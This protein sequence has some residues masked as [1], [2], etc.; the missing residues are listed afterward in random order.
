GPPRGDRG[1]SGPVVVRRAPKAQP[2]PWNDPAPPTVEQE[3]CQAVAEG[4]GLAFRTGD[5]VRHP[6]FGVG[7]VVDLEEGAEVKITVEFPGWGRKKLVARFV[8]RA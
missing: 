2:Q 3:I 8:E 6:R 4:A 5:R 1:R 7:R